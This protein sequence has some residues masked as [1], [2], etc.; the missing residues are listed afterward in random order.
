MFVPAV[1]A[2][3]VSEPAPAP[4]ARPRRSRRAGDATGIELEIAGVA[5]RIG[6]DASEAA[7]AAVIRALKAIP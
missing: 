7:I 5:V 1:I 6:A 4:A 3:A 2:P